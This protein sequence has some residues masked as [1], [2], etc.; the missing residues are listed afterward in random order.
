LRD[1]IEAAAITQLDAARRCHASERTMRQWLAGDRRMPL[2]ASECLALSLMWPG[3]SRRLQP[4]IALV[5]RWLRPQF[6]GL[7]VSM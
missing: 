1:L 7:V 6:A 2:A 4:S 5:E 3:Q